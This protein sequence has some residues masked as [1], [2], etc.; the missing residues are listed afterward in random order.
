MNS[1][2]LANTIL[3]GTE[4][5]TRGAALRLVVLAMMVA[6]AATLLAQQAEDI[7]GAYDFEHENEFIQLNVE[8][9][10]L[11]GYISRLGDETSDRGTPLTYFFKKAKT[12]GRHVIFTTKLVH[13]LWYSFDGAVERGSASRRED[14]GYYVLQGT[15]TM[16]RIDFQKHETAEKH[17]VSFRSKRGN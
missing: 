9:G 5:V 4:R 10:R 14:A 12:Q 15:M 17:G 8:N 2:R 13:G 16:H 6:A 7:S 3:R 11:D 1:R